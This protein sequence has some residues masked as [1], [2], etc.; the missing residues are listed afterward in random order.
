M[1]R[2]A[3]SAAAHNNLLRFGQAIREAR[4]ARGWTQADLADRLHEELGEFFNVS[5]IGNWE[6][7]GIDCGPTRR[8]ALQKI[9]GLRGVPPTEGHPK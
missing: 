7:Y 6:R 4:L 9:L 2:R 3:R 5:H 8:A 1:G